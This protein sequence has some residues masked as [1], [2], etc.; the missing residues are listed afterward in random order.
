MINGV[1]STDYQMFL[2]VDY[3]GLNPLFLEVVFW[4]R[5]AIALLLVYAMAAGIQKA[6]TPERYKTHLAS[7]RLVAIR[8]F[9]YY[10]WDQKPWF[11]GSSKKDDWNELKAFA[12]GGHDQEFKSAS[13]A[14]NRR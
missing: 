6:L 1:W 14:G 7:F 8:L 2:A 4:M 12:E 9:D 10:Q 11:T 3:L 13:R 5:V